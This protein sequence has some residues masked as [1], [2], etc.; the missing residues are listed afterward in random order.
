[1]LKKTKKMEHCEFKKHNIFLKAYIKIPK[2]KF[3]H[4]KRPIS[5]KMWILIKQLYLIR[6][7][8]GK[9]DLHI[10]LA[11]KTLTKLDLYV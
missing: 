7:L 9:K 5:I 4:H 10:L 6:S 8:L 1:M 2:Q 3:H 11:T